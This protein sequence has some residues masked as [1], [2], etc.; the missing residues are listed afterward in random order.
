M[1]FMNKKYYRVS[2]LSFDTQTFDGNVGVTSLNA[3]A[4]QPRIRTRS[5]RIYPKFPLSLDG[6][7]SLI[8]VC[9]LRLELY[10]CSAPG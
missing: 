10:G 6:D 2:I 9:C 8:N 4:L 7:A 5:V 1:N 3:I